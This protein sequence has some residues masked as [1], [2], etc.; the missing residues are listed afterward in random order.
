[1]KVTMKIVRSLEESGLLLKS[2]NEAIGN[3]VKEKTYGFLGILFDTLAASLL[4]NT[5]AGK[6]EI[7]GQV[8]IR[9]GEGRL[10]QVRI[11]NAPSSFE[12]F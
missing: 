10:E 5:L 6:T 7:P 11:F 8:L 3:E 1:M 4:G 12:K 2:V 9:E